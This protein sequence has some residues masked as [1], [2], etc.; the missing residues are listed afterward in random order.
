MN[1]TISEC[2]KLTTDKHSRLQTSLGKVRKYGIFVKGSA[3]GKSSRRMREMNG[4]LSL[5]PEQSR[6]IHWHAEEI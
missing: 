3:K 2:F 5:M 6:S 1:P 4:I